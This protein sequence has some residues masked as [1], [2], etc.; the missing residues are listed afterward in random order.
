MEGQLL[1]CYDEFSKG[2]GERA[3][4]AV[5]MRGREEGTEKEAKRR[6]KKRQVLL[7]V[8]FSCVCI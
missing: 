4:G 3:E 1:G 8:I 5:I 7:A 2:L 6:E